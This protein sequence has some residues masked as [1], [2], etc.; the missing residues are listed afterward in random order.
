MRIINLLRWVFLTVLLTLLRCVL[1][2][3]DMKKLVRIFNVTMKVPIFLNSTFNL[4]Y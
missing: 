2:K 4:L 1:L 3:E